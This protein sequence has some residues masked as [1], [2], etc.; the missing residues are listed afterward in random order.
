MAS[1]PL[2]AAM[3][4][5][6]SAASPDLVGNGDLLRGVLAGCGDC[7]KVL[8]LEGRLQ[9]MSES[10]KRVM[11]VD[12]F[13]K[14]KGC[15]WLEF[16]TGDGNAQAIAAVEAAKAGKPARFRAA[17]NTAKGNPRYWDVQVSPIFAADGRTTHLLS[18][19]KDI[20]EEWEA[21]ERERF[22]TEELEHRAKNTFAMILSIAN[23]TFRGAAHAEALKAYT[24]RVIALANAQDLA[25][26]SNWTSSPIGEVVETA[27]ASHRTGEGR[28]I[29]SGPRINIAP[30]QALSLTLAVNEL[31]T[32]AAKYGALSSA[33]GRIDISWSAEESA[34]P[35]FL[36][37]WQEHGGPPVTKPERQGFGSRLIKDFMANDFGGSV[38]L[39]YEC[40]GV[41]CELKS[42]LKNLPK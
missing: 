35:T 23:R 3:N 26:Q 36:F 40:D 14:L 41:V 17:A 9:F 6:L 8:D 20:T 21:A 10:G 24:A 30:K 25:K 27:L 38:Q 39:S 15:P 13:S 18:I 1:E 37:R 16:W 33:D 12:D 22:L 5:E 31:A 19:S 2:V 4:R 42:P 34:P 32:N 7:I 29:I 28:F 11:E